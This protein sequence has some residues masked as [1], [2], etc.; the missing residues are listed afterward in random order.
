MDVICDP[1]TKLWKTLGGQLRVEKSE[2]NYSQP[3]GKVA[4]LKFKNKVYFHGIELES[5]GY[6]DEEYKKTARQRF[7]EYLIEYYECSFMS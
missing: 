2:I 7:E 6:P 4:F 5:Y 3:L 1:K